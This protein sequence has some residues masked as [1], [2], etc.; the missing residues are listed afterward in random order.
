VTIN[1]SIPSEE[2]IRALLESKSAFAE[3]TFLG[4]LGVELVKVEVGKSVIKLD[5]KPHHL[6]MLDMVHGGVLASLL[7][8]A[9]GLAVITVESEIN[10]VTTNLNL[11]YLS[12]ARGTQLITSCE[13]VHRSRSTAT[14]TGTI[15]DEYGTLCTTGTA[16][17]RIITN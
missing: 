13:V 9:M 8:T 14:I 2:E 16:S 5:I 1:G 4:H 12:R 17:Y 7:D 3:T 6:N 11:H 15:T 10:A